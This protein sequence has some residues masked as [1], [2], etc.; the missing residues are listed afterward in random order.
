[1]QYHKAGWIMV[2]W[3]SMMA[4]AVKGDLG[5]LVICSDGAEQSKPAVSGNYAVWLDLRNGSTNKDIFGYNFSEPNEVPICI[6]AGNQDTPALSGNLAVW[7]DFRNGNNDIYGFYL[8]A[9]GVSANSIQGGEI[10]ICTAAASQDFPAVSGNIVVWRDKRND[11]NDIYGVDIT[12]L[13]GSS[14][15]PICT[16][17]TNQTT[18]SISGNIVVWIDNRNGENDIYGY[19]M[20]TQTEFPICTDAG[21]QY[22]AR[23]DGNIVVWMDDRNG[24]PDIYGIDITTLPG[25]SAFAI[26]LDGVVQ[27]N[28]AISGHHVVWEDQRGGG[29][30]IYG[31]DLASHSEFAVVT[32]AGDQKQPAI[33]GR[34]IVWQDSANNG[35]ICTAL[36]P[37]PVVLTLL[38]PNGGELFRAGGAC[39]VSWQSSGPLEEVKIEYSSNAG[40]DWSTLEAG[41]ANNGQWLWQPLPDIDSSQC[42]VRISDPLNPAAADQSDDNFIIFQCL[43]TLTADLNGDCRVDLADLVLF[44][45]QWLDCGNPYDPD[46]C[47]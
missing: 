24:N 1:M 10:A 40:G 33:N 41:I 8:P 2:L 11:N 36:I 14:D 42:R 19:N 32:A 34:R 45:G 46:W 6:A 26:C 37:E 39:A 4:A 30:D 20:A 22:N 21:G 25:G 43:A 29:Y 5:G 38:T 3:M 35:D 7:C 16:H 17:T 9:T 47:N 12:G 18:P 44:A 23:I 13:P 27:S 15:F 31:Y 28:P